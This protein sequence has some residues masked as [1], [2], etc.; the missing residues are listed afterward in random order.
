MQAV[1]IKKT[2]LPQLWFRLSVRSGVL[3]QL[4]GVLIGAALLFLAAYIDTIDGVRIALMLLGWLVIYICCHAIAH[5]AVGRL[6]GIHFRGF[7]VRGTDHPENYPP[8]L[9]QIMSC[10][11]FF[12]AMTEKNSMRQASPLAKALMFT[13]GETSTNLCSLLAAA[14][15]WLS[16]IPGGFTLFVIVVGWDTVSSIV[17]SIIPRGDYAKAIKALRR[18]AH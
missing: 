2:A 18:T 14:Y 3:V 13:A 4:A 12:T 15:A 9:R 10:I 17:V 1:T 11:P 6:V 8:A 5:W 16:G 7:G